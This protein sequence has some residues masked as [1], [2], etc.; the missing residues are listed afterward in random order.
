MFIP[1]VGLQTDRFKWIIFLSFEINTTENYL[2][3]CELYKR[4]YSELYVEART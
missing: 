1:I 2:V 3:V 4:T